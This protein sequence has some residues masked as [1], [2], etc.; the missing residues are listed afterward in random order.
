MKFFA[1]NTSYRYSS[2]TVTVT[3]ENVTHTELPIECLVPPNT[4]NYPIGECEKI[5]TEKEW[6]YKYTCKNKWDDKNAKHDD[7][8]RYPLPFN[9]SLHV[10]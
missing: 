3:G 6:R 10:V 7:S 8:Y 9:C 1:T 4:R 2:M 5:D